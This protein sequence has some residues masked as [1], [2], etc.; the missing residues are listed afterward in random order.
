MQKGAGESW[1]L[2]AFRGSYGSDG[3]GASAPYA[4]STFIAVNCNIAVFSLAKLTKL[5]R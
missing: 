3:Q 5:I 2:S 4:H 1:T